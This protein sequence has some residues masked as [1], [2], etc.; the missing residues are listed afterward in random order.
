MKVTVWYFILLCKAHFVIKIK[1]VFCIQWKLRNRKRRGSPVPVLWNFFL[2]ILEAFPIFLSPE[3]NS[4]IFTWISFITKF[5]VHI[6]NINQLLVLKFLFDP[7]QNPK[8]VNCIMILVLTFDHFD[9]CLLFFLL[10]V[11][12][13]RKIRKSERKDKV[14]SVIARRWLNLFH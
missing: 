3:K 14:A 12:T 4:L 11:Y 7:N 8:N 5:D 1:S 9:S 10:S 2:R 6:H 13:K